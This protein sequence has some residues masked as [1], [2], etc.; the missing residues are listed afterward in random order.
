MNS[1]DSTSAAPERNTLRALDDPATATFD[2]HRDLL[3]SLVYNM[4]GTV[5]D[6]EDVLQDTWLSWASVRQVDIV[7]ARAYLV[8]I[9]VN[10]ALR[11]L[12]ESQARREK[13]VGIWLPEPVVTERQTEDS[14][15][16]GESVSLAMMVVLETLSPLE[17]AVFVLREAFGYDYIEIATILD[18]TGDAVRQLA[19]RARKR[20]QGRQP[21]YRF[22]SKVVR[23]A[24]ERFMDAAL[25][26][27]VGTLMEI[28][29]P[30]VQLWS[31]GGGKLR[32]ALRVIVGRDKFVRLAA[33]TGPRLSAGLTHQYLEVNGAPAVLLSGQ[34]R[35]WGVVALELRPSDGRVQTIYNVINPDKLESI[36]LPAQPDGP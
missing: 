10:R 18:R 27:D 29:A 30:D 31:D 19:H 15:L 14:A 33:A 17:R 25:G 2:A 32:T 6:T 1:T 28:L 12:R 22:E 21:R 35:P 7:N 23:D 8:R 11:S 26:A 13:Y 5:A 20:V 9:A 34:N 16:R 3:F 4:L 24:T 36:I